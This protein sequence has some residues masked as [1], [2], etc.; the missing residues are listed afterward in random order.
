MSRD[1][2]VCQG[3]ADPLT[4][5]SGNVCY[6]IRSYKLLWYLSRRGISETTQFLRFRAGRAALAH[7]GGKRG[8]PLEG[9]G[10]VGEEKLDLRPGELVRVRPESEI[11][12]T[13]DQFGCHK[14]MRWMPMMRE[15]CGKTFP[16][17]KRV[18]KIVLE[19]T[20]EIR[21]LGGTVLLEGVICTGLY[22]C[23]RSC[24]HFW[25]EV[26]LQRITNEQL[27]R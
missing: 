17:Y 1:K 2:E 18:S 20:G 25:R 8:H 7:D 19:S 26:W 10:V 16:V 14:G 5:C 27:T 4:D 21:R 15:Y 3:Q 12:A 11:L 6:P 22:G 23:D 24:F 13:L 9:N